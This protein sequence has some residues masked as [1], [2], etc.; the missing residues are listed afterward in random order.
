MNSLSERL[1]HRIRDAHR[2]R[3]LTWWERTYLPAIAQGLLLTSGHFWRN[4]GLHIA[5]RLGLFRGVP[6]SVTIQYPDQLR[7][8]APRLRTPRRPRPAPAGRGSPRRT[9][10]V[11]GCGRVGALAPCHPP[12]ALI[13]SMLLEH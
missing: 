4:L 10:A 5:H 8:T 9:I 6:A 1:L 7:K 12:P 13:A 11:V 2:R 3:R